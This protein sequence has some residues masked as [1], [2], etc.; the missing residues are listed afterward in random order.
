MAD[1]NI[2][3]DV[4][5]V[6]QAKKVLK[7]FQGTVNGMTVVKIATGV[8][9]VKR[10]VEALIAA[11]NK[12]RISINAYNLGLLQ[13][14][15]ALEQFGVSSQ[16]ATA[17]VR[18]F[19][20]AQEREAQATAKLAQAKA[21]AETAFALGKQRAE[22]EARAIAQ[23]N[24]AKQEQA[25]RK[26]F[27]RQKYDEGYR[28]L[29]IYRTQIMELNEALE[30]GAI[31]QMQ[32]GQRVDAL[33]QQMAN[34]STLMLN[35][36][37]KSREGLN[38]FGMMTQ[39]AGYQ[40]GD[41]LVQVQ[42]GTNWMVA[43]GQQ[44]TQIAGTLT[45]FGGKWLYIGAALSVVIPLMTAVGAAIMRT[46]EGA[47]GSKTAFDE[48]SSALSDLAEVGVDFE[49][50]SENTFKKAKEGAQAFLSVLREIR[51]EKMNTVLED[52]V[53]STGIAKALAELE[54][55]VM[56][57]FSQEAMSGVGRS[58]EEI[59]DLAF[60]TSEIF[61]M[62]ATEAEQLN[63]ILKT[64][65]GTTKKE[66]ADSFLLAVERI[67]K[68]NL[69]TDETRAFIAKMADALGIVEEA[70]DEIDGSTESIL[71]RLK[72][73]TGTDL[74]SVFSK[75]AS[76]VDTMNAR[77][78]LTLSK[79]LG[80]LGAIG[81]IQF[82]TIAI[83]AE[84]KA[85][86]AGMTRS[87]ASVEARLARISAE[88]EQSGG[89][90]AGETAALLAYRKAL[91]DNAAAQDRLTKAT[92]TQ[93]KSTK[94]A[95]K[96]ANDLAKEIE[97]LEFDADPLKKYNAELAR[98]NELKKAGLSEGAYEKALAAANDELT[99]SVPI[100]SSLSKAFEG[101]LSGSIRSFKDFARTIFNDFKKLLADM[102]M[103]AL[104]NRIFIPIVTGGVG[105]AT[106]SGGGS[107][108]L[109]GGLSGL[110]SA[111]IGG[112]SNSIAAFGG[113]LSSGFAGIGAQFGAAS[114]G[115]LT[116]IAG[117]AGAVAPV[118]AAVAVVA[119]FFRSK[120]KE[121]DRGIKVVV[122]G[123]D[124]VAETF[125]RIQKSRFW[126]LSKKT[127]TNFTPNEDLTNAF[128]SILSQVQIFGKE[129][130]LNVDKLKDF[131]TELTLSTKGLSE[132]DAQAVILKALTDFGDQ[133]AKLISNGMS[134]ASLAALYDAPRR[135]L[136]Q[137]SETDPLIGYNIE[138]FQQMMNKTT[139]ILNDSF[140][141]VGSIAVDGVESFTQSIVNG[142]GVIKG[143][144]GAVYNY[145]MTTLG[146]LNE[147]FGLGGGPL[148]N[149]DRIGATLN[150]IFEPAER[151]LRRLEGRLDTREVEVSAAAFNGDISKEVAD[152][153]QAEIQEVSASIAKAALPMR[154]VQR[155]FKTLTNSVSDYFASQVDE[156][157][158]LVFP[159]AANSMSAFVKAIIS[160]VAEG[161]VSSFENAFINLSDALGEG[162]VSFEDYNRAM[163]IMDD[164]FKGNISLTEEYTKK[165]QES[166]DKIAKV[167]NLLETGLK[168]VIN[169]IN[170]ALDKLT[171]SRDDLLQQN[172]LR[173]QALAF[174]A[175][176][177]QSGEI[178]VQDQERFNASVS[179]VSD[180]TDAEF[181]SSVDMLRYVG[182][183]AA[184]LRSIG[185]DAQRQLTDAQLQVQAILKIEK[186]N[187]TS[188][189]A[190]VS[191]DAAIQ[192]FL[193]AGGIIPQFAAGGYHSG[194][195]RIVGENGPELEA[196][197]PARIYTKNQLAG[198]SSSELRQEIAD[199]RSELSAALLQIAKNTRKSYETLNKFDYQGLPQD[200]GY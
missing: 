13:T 41:F 192:D 80:I 137:L 110:G 86:E 158:A 135:R 166:V 172:T 53:S 36:S 174:L 196:T 34:G 8:D 153:L 188:A 131:N 60:E 104:R 144:A 84:T 74:S 98:L 28:A 189:D 139:K 109:L 107:G 197:G 39:Q 117:A 132:E 18:G 148:S 138:L 128:D 22:E 163:K 165:Q 140:K 90:D 21:R 156:A 176:I 2:T 79:I 185:D 23:L 20:Q 120:T 48:A 119:S 162:K 123:L 63:L 164:V 108:G 32:H 7:D 93:S 42:S 91:E 184:L 124:V 180:V 182:R 54:Q 11:K 35:A 97:K 66:I 125:Q 194:G 51:S 129:L 27:L 190:L 183:T 143:A 102:I 154:T 94:G 26:N 16:K 105:G 118:L 168:S 150:R 47:K 73:M 75:A 37:Q 77:L 191:I 9:Q 57:A 169:T 78:D 113:G 126:G 15:R 10:N 12:G 161:N 198:G 46:S 152:K 95:A 200:R 55:S 29:V 5:S 127:S 179:A 101:F 187:Q 17:I 181:S 149:L 115:S 155:G 38:R 173:G 146:N 114:A 121:L 157:L 175:G 69:L 82:D 59:R 136:A 116:A 134:L 56:D 45:V 24:D 4:N 40:V 92:D 14:K 76:S 133:A 141:S 33:N 111:F 81:S 103:T 112:A 71:E 145:L 88:F 70:Y 177:A 30:L 160:Q 50:V 49:K 3:V 44:A 170:S 199:M 61:G 1:I 43:F 64:I 89:I 67:E 99:N 31:N 195:L 122:E 52:M 68:A 147:E 106:G 193:A 19:A 96:A 72:S 151:E 65:G 58:F 159:E 142:V 62:T 25:K 130:G 171:K 178:P 167:F 85:L 6:A 186:T 83:E 87:Q 100:I